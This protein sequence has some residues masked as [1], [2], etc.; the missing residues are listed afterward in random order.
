MNNVSG[1]NNGGLLS[2]IILLNVDSV[3]LLL[4]RCGNIGPLIP[5]DEF[6]VLAANLRRNKRFD[7]SPRLTG[8]MLRRVFRC[9]HIFS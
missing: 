8:W 3:L 2:D 5:H 4:I 9:V 6:F 1:Q 7:I